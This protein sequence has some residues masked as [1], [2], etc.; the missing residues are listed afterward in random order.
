[1]SN[2][3]GWFGYEFEGVYCELEKGHVGMHQ[4]TMLWTLPEEYENEEN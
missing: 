1:M 4:Y 2:D 3:V